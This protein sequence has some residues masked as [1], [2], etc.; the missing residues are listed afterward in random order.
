MKRG[1]F[2]YAPSPFNKMPL[3]TK[4]LAVANAIYIVDKDKN[5]KSL[6]RKEFMK[7]VKETEV[8]FLELFGGYTHDEINHGK[9]VSKDGRIMDEQV[10]RIFSFSYESIFLKK[11]KELQKWIL[12]KKKEWNQEAMAYEFEGDLFYI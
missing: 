5:G 10:A 12:K 1:R 6:S 7:R 11:R 3:G 9:F 2:S 8:K 4:K